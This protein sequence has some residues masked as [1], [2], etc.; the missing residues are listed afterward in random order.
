MRLLYT[1]ALTEPHIKSGVAKKTFVQIF[2]VYMVV[3]ETLPA[4]EHIFIGRG[5]LPASWVTCHSTN[6]E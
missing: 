5:S 2:I 4:C 1:H 3:L 6:L